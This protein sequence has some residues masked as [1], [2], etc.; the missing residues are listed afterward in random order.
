MSKKLP[1]PEKLRDLLSYDP[2]TGHLTWKPRNGKYLGFFN[3]TFAGKIA[4]T[5]R[6]DGYISV[7]IFDVSY[8]AH[9]LIWAMVHDEWPECVRHVN[10]DDADNRLANLRASTRVEIGRD[11]GAVTSLA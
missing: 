10:R 8:P 6:T 4:G 7:K 9:R 5:L 2:E 1:T 3:Y 11:R